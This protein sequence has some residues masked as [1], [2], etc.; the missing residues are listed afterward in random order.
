MEAKAYDSHQLRARSTKE[1]LSVLLHIIS[2]EWS[3]LRAIETMR[4]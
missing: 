1:R 3:S 2:T 4:F